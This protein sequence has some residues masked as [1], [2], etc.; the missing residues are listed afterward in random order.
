MGEVRLRSIAIVL[1]ILL[2]ACSSNAETTTTA[3]PELT[4]WTY[5]LEDGTEVVIVDDGGDTGFTGAVPTPIAIID[6]YAAAK[7]CSAIEGE[8]DFWEGTEAASSAGALRI[9]AYAEYGQAQLAAAG[10]IEATPATTSTRVAPTTTV[11]SV[12]ATDNGQ[13]DCAVATADAIETLGTTFNRIDV[14]PDAVLGDD[15]T[16]L[17][18]LFI[19][20]GRLLATACTTVPDRS[21]AWSEMMV[22][23]ADEAPNRQPLTREFISGVLS[24]WCTAPP[25]GVELTLQGRAACSGI[26]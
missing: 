11:T 10:C 3:S 2:G 4:E 14:D 17:E 26:G 24:V 22:Y 8:I 16:A 19:E 23:L 15:S 6:E 18:D 25:N 20:V 21:G 5:V 13:D 9:G 12:V 1:V 7:D